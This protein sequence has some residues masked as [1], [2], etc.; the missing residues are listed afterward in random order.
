MRKSLLTPIMTEITKII[1]EAPNIKTF[2]VSL[3]DFTEPI[4]GQFNMIYIKGFGE[5]PISVSEISRKG[6]KL[7]IGHTIRAIGSVTQAFFNIAK[8]GTYI[9]IR[10]PYGNGW[11]LKNSTG[12]DIMIIAGGIGLAPL[13]PVIKYVE[14]HRNE[15]GKLIILYGARTPLDMI[16][17]YELDKYRLIPDTIVKLS[18][19]KPYPGWREYVGF[20]TDLINMVDIDSKNVDAYVCGPEIMMMVATKKLISKGLRKDSI[21][22]SLERRM[23]CGVGICGT[24]QLGHL[25]VCKDGPVFNYS[26]IEDYLKVEGL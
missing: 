21:Y 13:R 17:K 22:L 10:G 1:D 14:N 25:F 20:V 11:P 12:R 18:I 9:G 8:I 23:R 15:Y 7:I 24:C 4:P 16:F 6:N 3:T 26:M 19:D 2:Y 5:V